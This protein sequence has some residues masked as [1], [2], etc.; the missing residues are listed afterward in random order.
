MR[1][2]FTPHALQR[3]AE[4][5]VERDEVGLALND[6]EVVYPSPPEHPPGRMTHLH[7]RIG[8]IV[9]PPDRIVT[10]VWRT[11]AT[12]RVDRSLDGLV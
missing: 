7:G 5:G 6:P 12:G 3:L 8:V 10:I 2:F 11:S 9:Q 4:M 1:P